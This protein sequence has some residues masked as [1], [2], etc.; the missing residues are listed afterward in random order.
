MGI[1]EEGQ[2]VTPEP[3]RVT[4]TLERSM[5]PQRSEPVTPVWVAWLKNNMDLSKPWTQIWHD[6]FSQYPENAP[7]YGERLLYKER[8]KWEHR[9]LGIENIRQLYPFDAKKAPTWY[10]NATGVKSSPSTLSAE[11]P[12]EPS[13]S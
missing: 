3:E 8:I 6:D 2:V 13:K 10:R 9:Y 11:A 4:H 5:A 12:P 1:P 7:M